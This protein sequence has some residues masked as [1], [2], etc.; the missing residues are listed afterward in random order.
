MEQPGMHAMSY[1]QRREMLARHH[2][3]TLWVYW[4]LAILGIW[5]IISP[6]TFD[7]SFGAD[8]E[9]L[10]REVWLT[11]S[12]RV[13]VMQWSD[14]ISGILLTVFAWRSLAP[15]RPVSLWTCCA[16]GIWLTLAPVLFW[17]PNALLYLNNTLV[18]MLV[19]SLSILIPGMPNM[20]MYM[21]MGGEV[22]PG[23]SYNPSSWAQRWILIVAGFAGWLVSRY[24]AAFQLGYLDSVY[25]P[26]FAGGTRRVLTSDMSRS[27]PISDAALGTLAYTFEFLMGFMG[28]PARWRTMPWMV[29]IF[30]FLVI[31]LGLVHIVLVIS[32]PLV[33]GEWCTMCILAAALMLPMIPLEADE[34]VAMGQHVWQCKK[35]G[36]SAWKVFWKGGSPLGST[37][38]RRMPKLEN[39][40]MQPKRV[41]YAS[42][43]GMSFPFSL[44][45]STM[46]GLWIIFTP[47]LFGT[48][49]TAADLN[50]LIGSLVVTVS[51][52]SM[53]EVLR[54]GRYLNILLALALASGILII[55]GSTALAAISNITVAVILALFAL[56]KGL[57]YERYGLWQKYVR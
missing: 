42:I 34:V 9:T 45:L 4:T 50:Y 2:A 1:Q 47:Y 33:V 26:L 35:R 53:G 43:V 30:G 20:I 22:P 21:Q 25:D 6:L 51:V 49:G 28:S 44:V 16:I 13:S 5:M 40:P 41:L 7:Y 56:P 15:N 52:I 18:G 39:L 11:F 29:A 23:W 19:I 38:D 27:W 57:I 36:E 31:P 54:A 32:Q 12:E 14:F 3:Q 37:A 24:L 55:S 48:S 46:L 17:A 8:E 10:G